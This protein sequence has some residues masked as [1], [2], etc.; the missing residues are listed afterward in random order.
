MARR[1]GATFG[2]QIRL[3]GYDLEQEA[4]ALRLVLHWQAVGQVSVDGVVFV[5]LFDP[6]SEEIAVQ[7]DARP[8]RGTY[9][10]RWWR[11]DEVVSEEIVLALEDVPAA[12]YRLAVGIYDA[13]DK[14]RL[15]VVN[16]S[17]ETLPDGRLIL[18]DVISVPSPGQPGS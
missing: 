8:Q 13:G 7:S 10:T 18:E 16:V 3:L 6:A 2:G 14:D 12:R 9:P 5:H 17:G 11:A 4:Q 1:V 15:T